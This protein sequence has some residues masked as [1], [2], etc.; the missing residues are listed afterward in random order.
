MESKLPLYHCSLAQILKK[1]KT[2]LKRSQKQTTFLGSD[3]DMGQ[4][5]YMHQLV[6]DLL[7]K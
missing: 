6:W 5:N 7:V 3:G 1:T 2:K 4:I